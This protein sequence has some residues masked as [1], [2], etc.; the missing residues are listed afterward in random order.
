MR[1]LMGHLRCRV[2]SH[3]CRV[4]AMKAYELRNAVRHVCDMH[5]VEVSF[6]PTNGGH[7]RATLQ[8]RGQ[9]RVIHF[10]SS[11]SDWRELNNVMAR[12]RRAIREM[13]ARQTWLEPLVE[14]ISRPGR[15]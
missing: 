8:W 14:V 12:T 15:P 10:S 2:S 4:A 7:Q 9:H 6:A 13:A 5:N 3:H 1:N 11:G